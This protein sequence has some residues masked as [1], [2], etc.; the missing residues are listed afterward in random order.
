MLVEIDREK[1]A[2]LGV[3]AMQI[4][5]ALNN[6]YGSPQ[7]STIYTPTN[8]YW[9]MMELLPQYQRDPAALSLLY[10][11][12]AGGK[13][14]PLGTVAK[15]TRTVGPLT[16][17]HLGQLPAVTVSFNLRPGVPLGDAVGRDPE[18]WSAI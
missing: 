16:V 6:A 17:N 9:V 13:L 2:A 5:A 12:S 1:A 14:V 18:A 10:I 3:T 15:L 11:R 8:Q 4:E 7:V